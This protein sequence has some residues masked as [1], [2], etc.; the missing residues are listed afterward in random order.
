MVR[1]TQ[2]SD[3]LLAQLF[4]LKGLYQ[5]LMSWICMYIIRPILLT[6]IRT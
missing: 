3:T 4:I 1:F 5:T 6:L 2:R